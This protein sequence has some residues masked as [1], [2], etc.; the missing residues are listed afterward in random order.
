MPHDDPAIEVA[1]RRARETFG[2][3]WREVWWERRRIVGGLDLA[4][5]KAAFV[6]G[7]AVEH[8]WVVDVDFDGLTV[9]GTVVNEPLDLTGVRP[10]DRVDVELDEVEDWLFAVDGLAHGGFTIAAIRAGLGRLA[11]RRHDRAWGLRFPDEV[12]LVHGQSADPARLD[13]HPLCLAS[14]ADL[15]ATLQVDRSLAMERD[16]DGFTLLHREAIAGDAP[17]VVLL[18]AFGAD[19]AARSPRGLTAEEHAERLGWTRVVEA[20]HA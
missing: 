19:P 20:M 3:F 14:R 4:A 1:S 9:T 12:L 6:E 7:D 10:G 2:Y 8:L 15:A 13:D 5:V 18:L 16:E 17:L 11:R